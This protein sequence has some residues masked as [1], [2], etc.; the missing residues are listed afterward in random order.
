MVVA[1]PADL[2]AIFHLGVTRVLCLTVPALC[3]APVHGTMAVKQPQLEFVSLGFVQTMLFLAGMKVQCGKLP[4]LIRC[5]EISWLPVPMTGRSLSGRKKMAHGKRHTSTRG[6]TRQV[7]GVW[8]WDV[9]L[10]LR[11]GVWVGINPSLLR[12]KASFRQ[13]GRLM[14]RQ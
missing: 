5:M 12:K 10:G 9:K 4:G 1:L 8:S 14:E 11:A 3:R 13:T 6:T 7:R 2:H